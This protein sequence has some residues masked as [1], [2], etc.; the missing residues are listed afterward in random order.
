MKNSMKTLFVTACSGMLLTAGSQALSQQTHSMEASDQVGAENIRFTTSCDVGTEEGF[1][2]GIALMH[3]FWFAEAIDNFEQVLEQ[4]PDCA[5]AHWG[6]ALSHWGNPFAGRRNQQ[7]LERGQRAVEQARSTGSPSEREAQYIEAV[8]ELFS[9]NRPENQRQRTLAY[10]AAMADLAAAYPEDIEARIFHALAINQNAVPGDQS[11]SK[12]LEAAQVLEPLFEMHP[13][14]PGLAHYIIHAYD[15]PP[16]AERALD[17]A[18]R[19]ASL[20]PDAPHALHMPSHTFTRIGHWQESVDTNKRSAAAASSAGEELHALDYMAYAYLQMGRDQE[21]A[22]VVRRAEELADDVDITAVGATQAGAFALAA[23]PARYALERKAFSEAAALKVQP[24]ELPQ[25]QAMA[26]FA[27]AVGAARAGVP[28]AATPDIEQLAVLRDELIVGSDDYW[29]EQVDIQWQVARA[30]QR[31]AEGQEEE[32]ITLLMAAAEAE[33]GTDKSAVS[34]GPLAPAREL[35]GW[36]LLEAG[37]NDRA[38]DAFRAT[39][40]KEPNRFLGL[41]GAGRAAEALGDSEAAGEYYSRLLAVAAEADTDRA[42]LR[43]A[44]LFVER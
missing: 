34:P 18:R 23:I 43:H 20:A 12:Q 42:E 22:D 30:W 7:Q 32:G 26:H 13:D 3:S 6:I 2:R 21:A 25:T 35:L 44:N 17:A 4:D 29:A 24:S 10:E 39:V 27:R 11:Y 28:A 33:D 36:M 31:F 40:E 19:Y 38:L 16:L 14:H 15:H 8:A 9:D 41:Y 1:H 37:H 5:I